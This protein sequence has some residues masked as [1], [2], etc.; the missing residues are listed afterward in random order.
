MTFDEHETDIILMALQRFAKE[1]ERQMNG[2]AIEGC[3]GAAWYA[4][5][6]CSDE[7]RKVIARIE[8]ERDT[9]AAIEAAAHRQAQAKP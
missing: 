8:G 3:S 4:T 6:H 7:V 2:G 5:S 9:V 1:A